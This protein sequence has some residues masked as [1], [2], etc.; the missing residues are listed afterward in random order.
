MMPTKAE[1]EL[2]SFL[3]EHPHLRP[4]QDE[5]DYALNSVDCSYKRQ[6]VLA[7]LI[8]NKL[9]EL[10]HELKGLQSIL[11]KLKEKNVNGRA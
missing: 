2:D 1:I 3:N 7:F 4:L 8:T 5:I 10:M 11:S 9:E 6:A